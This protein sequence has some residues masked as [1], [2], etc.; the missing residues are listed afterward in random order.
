MIHIRVSYTYTQ[1]WWVSACLGC[2]HYKLNC[3]PKVSVLKWGL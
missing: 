2:H 1:L 3:F